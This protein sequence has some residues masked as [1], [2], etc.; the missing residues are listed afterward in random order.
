MNK[1]K[2]KRKSTEADKIIFW[3][4]GLFAGYWIGRTICQIIIELLNT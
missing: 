2:K 1:N 3:I 4:C